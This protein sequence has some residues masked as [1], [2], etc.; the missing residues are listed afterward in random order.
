MCLTL[1]RPQGVGRLGGVGVRSDDILLAMG[2]KGRK[3]GMGSSQGQT[4]RGMKSGR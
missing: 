3:H 2:D 1:E 4:R